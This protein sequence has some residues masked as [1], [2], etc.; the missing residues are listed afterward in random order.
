MGKKQPDNAEKKL[1][2]LLTLH[3]S[4]LTK[5]RN[6]VF[7]RD[8]NVVMEHERDGIVIRERCDCCR[9]LNQVS[10]FSRRTC[11]RLMILMLW[12]G[13]LIVIP[14][15]VG[16]RGLVLERL[17]AYSESYDVSHAVIVGID[18]YEEWPKLEG[19]VADA[20]LMAQTLTSLGFTKLTILKNR[21]AHRQAVMHI[22]GDVLPAQVGNNDR[23][24]V[25]FAGHGYTETLPSGDAMGYLIPVDGQRRSIYA[26][27]ISMME[28]RTL[29][30]RIPAKHILFL[31]DAC[32]S[33]L[34]LSR[35][36]GPRP[37]T[38]HFVRKSLSSRAVEILTAGGSGE[39]AQERGRHGVF[40]QKLVNG[41]SGAADLAP[42]DGTITAAELAEYVRV[43]VTD[44]TYGK[45]TPQFGRLFGE[46]EFLF[47]GTTELNK[48]PSGNKT[49]NQVGTQPSSA[50]ATSPQQPA[51]LR[52][53][54]VTNGEFRQFIA[55]GG[56]D[57]KRYWHDTGWDLCKRKGW[58]GPRFS[59]S[60]KLTLA[61]EPV[62]GISW[63]EA[64]AYC[65]WKGLQLPSAAEYEA[66]C[67]SGF[68]FGDSTMKEWTRDRH[69]QYRD[70]YIVFVGCGGAHYQL[71]DM[72]EPDVG[73]RVV[74]SDAR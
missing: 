4:F 53:R 58:V 30:E 19:A 52:G 16:E 67:R 12:A 41:L 21:E 46:G 17:P 57:A 64:D 48:T 47:L 59:R 10:A 39:Q 22:L 42:P 25:Y 71:P 8:V 56:Y 23:V 54:L 69:L 45:Q 26:T 31:I 34:C 32:Y 60:S 9:N 44:A 72:R 13:S 50:A 20:E 49:S 36:S 15:T 37:T 11:L 73:F 24:V 70:T 28:L 18:A 65:R 61:G 6:R 3:D 33:G 66:A 55:A 62:V 43:N 40:T 2:C 63:Y 68:T 74:E 7:I 29:A 35:G 14:S 1:E 51:T 38:D 5:L 27:G